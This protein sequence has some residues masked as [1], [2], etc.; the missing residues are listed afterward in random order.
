MSIYLAYTHLAVYN[1]VNAI[2]HRFQ[3]Y[4][5]EIPAPAGASVN[6]AVIS[7]AT[8]R[9]FI[10]GSIRLS[11]LRTR[12]RLVCPRW[13]KDDG[14]QAGKAAANAIIAM[15]AGDGRGETHLLHV[16]VRADSRGVWIPTPPAHL[17]PQLLGPV[18]W[19]PSR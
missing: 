12:V 9:F 1:A 6:A 18:R 17:L 11:G 3:P 13:L 19:C 15:R 8:T 16:S 4:G 2:D 10:A 14:V 7:A 5:A